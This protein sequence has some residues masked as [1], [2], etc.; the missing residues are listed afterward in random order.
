MAQNGLITLKDVRL[1]EENH[2]QAGKTFRETA[3]VLR[4][5]RYMVGWEA[6]G[7]QMGA[8]E[9]RLKYAQERLQFGKPIG[10]FQLIQDLLAKMIAN[11]TACQCL[12]VRMAELDDQDK[13]TDAQAALSKAFTTAKCRETVAWGREIFGGNGISIDYN[14]GR[15]FTDAEALV[16]YE[17]TIRCR[18]SFSAKPSPG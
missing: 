13:M 17:G 11:V 7:C 1:P 15:F 16:S 8:F 4:Q 2:L 12:V 9:H 5:T 14:I 6:T 18:T 3:R 10:S